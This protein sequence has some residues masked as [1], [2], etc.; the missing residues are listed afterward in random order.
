[1]GALGTGYWKGLMKRNKHPVK[2]GM[3]ALDDMTRNKKEL[4]RRRR[5]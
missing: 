1:M 4:R 2:L 5:E 3:E